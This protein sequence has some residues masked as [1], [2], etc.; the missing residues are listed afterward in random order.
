MFF[1]VKIF[2]FTLLIWTW[3]YS[4]KSTNFGK[5]CDNKIRNNNALHLRLSRLLKDEAEEA[6]LLYKSLKDSTTNVLDADDYTFKKRINTSKHYDNSE[7]ST[8]PF[9][10]SDK[11]KKHNEFKVGKHSEKQSNQLKFN[12]NLKK[13]ADI[14]EYD[15]DIGAFPDIVECYNYYKMG[16]IDTSRMR[17]EMMKYNIK[18]KEHSRPRLINIFKKL[19]RHI[20]L[21]ML[22]LMKSEYII[23]DDD[24][25]KGKSIFGKILYYMKKY[26]II[27]PPLIIVLAVIMLLIL[28]VDDKIIVALACVGIAVVI[29]YI[30]KLRKCQKIIR[31]FKQIRTDNKHMKKYR[32]PNKRNL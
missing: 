23:C 19:D 16:N 13:S 2:V 31:L 9:K 8:Y 12:G 4:N 28:S 10:F 6:V 14:T 17:F 15:I 11:R 22:R 29:Y 30:I 21:G 3:E 27:S 20:E 25:I 32:D 18:E 24:I 7:K 5:T 26:R 1:S